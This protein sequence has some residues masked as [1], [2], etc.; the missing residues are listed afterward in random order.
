MD[1]S[2]TD[3]QTEKIEKAGADIFAWSLVNDSWL[4][5]LRTK[6]G[7][8]MDSVEIFHLCLINIS[9]CLVLL[10]IRL[11]SFMDSKD[12]QFVEDGCLNHVFELHR[13]TSGK[14]PT[15]KDLDMLKELVKKNIKYIEDEE[16]KGNIVIKA[17]ESSIK[18]TFDKKLPDDVIISYAEQFTEFFEKEDI[19]K[20]FMG[21][22]TIS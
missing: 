22:M 15:K 6:L 18:G 12:V 20:N 1:K 13:L 14:K 4:Y 11:E 10:K 5:Q 16:I 7:I 3:I 17:Y 19:T 21:G 9:Y 2:N 8:K